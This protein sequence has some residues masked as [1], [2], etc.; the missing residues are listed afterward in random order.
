MDGD[1]P[2]GPCSPIETATGEFASLFNSGVC[3]TQPYVLNATGEACSNVAPVSPFS[4]VQSDVYWSSSTPGP[5]VAWIMDLSNGPV[6]YEGKTNAS[7]V[8]PVRGGP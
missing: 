2:G 1:Y 3:N 7:Y 5:S 4:G 8:W 6:Y